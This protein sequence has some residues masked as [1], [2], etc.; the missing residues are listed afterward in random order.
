M[1]ALEGATTHERRLERR[2]DED[3]RRLERRLDEDARL[4]ARPDSRAES[5][6]AKSGSAAS[7]KKFLFEDVLLRR[8]LVRSPLFLL[9][10]RRLFSR[11]LS[12]LEA[13]SRLLRTALRA[14][15]KTLAFAAA[16]TAA[17]SFTCERLLWSALAL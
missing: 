9:L 17:A 11:L 3:S 5:S 15:P 2:P 1:S 6:A 4:D 12:R 16:D 14:A 8:R 10:L 13:M 7:S